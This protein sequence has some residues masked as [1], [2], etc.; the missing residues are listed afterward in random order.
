MQTKKQLQV[1]ENTINTIKQSR[2]Q[3]CAHLDKKAFD[4]SEET[5][6]LFDS[7]L[8]LDVKDLLDFAWETLDKIFRYCGAE[9]PPQ[10]P[11]IN[12][13]PKIVSNLKPQ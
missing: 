3:Y 12:D 7:S 4:E 9:L 6:Y 8:Y 11:L 1:S 10:F 13:L 2:D 5:P